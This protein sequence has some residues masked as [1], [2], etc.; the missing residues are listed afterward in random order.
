M[1]SNDILKNYAKRLHSKY[2][3][4]PRFG[5]T[6][7]AISESSIV[8]FG[9]AIYNPN[10]KDSFRMTSDLY[11]YNANDNI[12]KKLGPSNSYTHP[13]LPQPRAAHA[14]AT[15]KK[16]MVFYYGG[17]IGNGQYTN[18]E[19][20]QL[21]IKPTKDAIWKQVPIEGQTPGARYGH[22]MT[23]INPNVFLFGGSSN[24]G[25]NNKKYFLNDVWILRTDKTPFNW[26]KLDIKHSSILTSRLYHTVCVYN[27]INGTNSSIVLFGGRNLDNV[28]LNDLYLLKKRKNKNNYKWKVIAPKNNEP[29]PISRYQHS[30]AMFGPFLFIMGGR[31]T[32]SNFTTFDVFSFISKSWYTFGSVC[33][34][35]HTIW[36]YYNVSKQEEIKLYLYIYGGFSSEQNNVI[37]DKLYRI[38]ILKLFSDKEKLKKELNEYL[39]LL[40]K[41]PTNNLNINTNDKSNNNNEINNTINHNSNNYNKTFFNNNSNRINNH[42]HNQFNNTINHN[43]NNYN[44][45]FFNNNSNRINNNNGIDSIINDNSNNNND[46]NYFSNN[47]NEINNSILS[48]NSENN[49]NE[50]NNNLNYDDIFDFSS[51]SNGSPKDDKIINNINEESVTKDIIKK[52]EFKKCSICLEMYTVGTK[53]SFLP[54]CHYFHSK[55]IKQLLKKSKNCPLCKLEIKKISI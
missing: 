8:I 36:I 47:N 28:S 7:N 52:V 30:S 4:P 2:L 20:W 17:S 13:H 23:Y 5:H 46:S 38:D 6:V 32:H 18:D 14:S 26:I 27:K 12:W 51:D 55:C 34:F 10:K 11:L 19:L 43:S 40:K 42:N 48:N 49:N 35:R 41:K 1:E 24:F 37:N 22:C 31:S 21:D 39:L 9:G 29:S 25:Q 53:M 15:I 54:C 33:L 16:N 3:P 44:N 50:N 45:T